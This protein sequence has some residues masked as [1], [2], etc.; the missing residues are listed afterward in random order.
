MQRRNRVLRAFGLLALCALLLGFAGGTVS[1]QDDAA[2]LKVPAGFAVN[3][4][5]SGLDAPRLMTVGPDG[6]LYVAERDAK[7]IVMLPDANNDGKADAK[8]VI[9]QSNDLALVHN[10]EWHDGWLYAATG[11]SV[12]RYQDA[13]NDGKFEKAE[14]VTN[15]IPAAVHHVSRTVHFGPDGKMYV[16]TGSSSN[17]NPETDPRRAAVLRFNADGSIPADN[18]YANDANPNRRPIYAEGLRNAI[19]FIFTPGGRLWANQNGSDG[20]GDNTPPEEIVIDVQSGKHYGWPY[21][22]T[23]ALGV[24]AAN[25]TEVRD[26]RVPLAVLSGCND[27]TPA[28]FTDLAHSAP[29]GMVQYE[30]TTFPAKYRGTLLVAYHGSWNS[31]VARDCKVQAIIVQDGKP[32]SSED[33]L[34]GFRSS[35]AQNCG[36]AWGRPAGVAVGKNGE[37]YVSDDQNGNIYRV[38]YTGK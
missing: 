1:A 35:A 22:Y 30:G 3:I 26:S 10:V 11:N 14:L 5:A 37:L 17:N 7:S 9:A 27:A 4:F 36:S 20:L 25:V 19:D 13:N 8:T 34:T 24:V 31:S 29:I 32:V 23:P 15:N 18:P 16:S 6:N 38:V 2:R 12:M 21:C 28:V 33:F